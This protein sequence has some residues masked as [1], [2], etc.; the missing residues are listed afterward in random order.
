LADFPAACECIAKV[1]FF[2]CA[3][4]LLV[5]ATGLAVRDLSSRDYFQTPPVWSE[6]LW[7]NASFS[8]LLPQDP[9][10]FESTCLDLA[11]L[12]LV[13]RSYRPV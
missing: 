2:S 8:Y 3:Q 13:R 4:D 5:R 6:P 10:L 11:S 7:F 1:G 12:P 9:R